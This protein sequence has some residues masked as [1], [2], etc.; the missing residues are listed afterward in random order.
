MPVGAREPLTEG[1]LI[2]GIDVV[3]RD[4]AVRETESGL[5]R[6]GHAREDVW[7]RDQA[8]DDDGDVVLDL[9]LE[10]GGVFESNDLAV[11]DR[12]REAHADVV[13]DG[14]SERALLLLHDGCDQ[15]IARALFEFHECVGDLLHR[16]ALD[17]GAALRTVRDADA[18]PEQSHVVVDLGD[19]SD[20]R[21]GV[22][23]GRLLVDRDGWAQ[24][25]DEVDI[26]AVDLPQELACI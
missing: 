8:V 20:C 12:P 10:L 24:A 15:L 16:L 23:V 13:A 1:A 5:D 4:Q 22:S 6:V 9:L 19:R 21:T 18:C 14:V 11:D 25:L 7:A 26:G 2:V 17:A 3:D